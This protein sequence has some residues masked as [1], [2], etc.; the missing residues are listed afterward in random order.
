M[1]FELPELKIEKFNYENILTTSATPSAAQ[2]LADEMKTTA[3][4]G[5][6]IVNWTLYSE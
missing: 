2:T 5:V 1:K 6:N 4:G 3:T